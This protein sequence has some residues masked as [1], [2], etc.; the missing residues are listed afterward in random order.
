MLYSEI[1]MIFVNGVFQH[2]GRTFPKVDN[3]ILDNLMV[4]TFGKRTLSP[5]SENT[6]GLTVDGHEPSEDEWHM[7]SDT[8]MTMFDSKWSREEEVFALVYNPD[9][10]YSYTHT[11]TVDDDTSENTQSSR[12]EANK[13]FGFDSETGSDKSTADTSGETTVTHDGIRTTITERHGNVAFSTSKT[14]QEI[15]TQELEFRK[16]NHI[17][18]VLKDV[19]NL[20]TLKVY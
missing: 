12:L 7:L 18:E 1:P 2:M 9:D 20:L 3:K 11:N 10:S 16:H 13:E 15:L 19:A 8:L 4:N 17:C 6:L 14:K 5:L